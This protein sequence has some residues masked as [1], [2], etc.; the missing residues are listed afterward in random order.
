M[1]NTRSNIH[2]TIAVVLLTLALSS[3]SAPAQSSSA[4]GQ[5]VNAR[6]NALLSRMSLLEKIGQ[7]T[8]VGALDLKPEQRKRFLGK[9]TSL[10]QTWDSAP[11]FYACACSRR[12]RVGNPLMDFPAFFCATRIS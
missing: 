8:Q 3:S 10:C 6:V 1:P 11:E 5:K 4:S 7:L 12:F 9:A 2:S